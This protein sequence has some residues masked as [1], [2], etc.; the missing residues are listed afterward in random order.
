MAAGL[1]ARTF[2]YLILRQLNRKITWYK[3]TKTKSTSHVPALRDFTLILGPGGAAGCAPAYAGGVLLGTTGAHAPPPTPSLVASAPT[4][5][6][7]CCK[8]FIFS[9]IGRALFVGDGTG[10]DALAELFSRAAFR[11]ARP[12]NCGSAGADSVV[13]GDSTGAAAGAGA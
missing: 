1:Q 7:C 6:V 13:A 5:T 12:V 3:T 9:D 10:M 11:A 2:Q 4:N 8:A